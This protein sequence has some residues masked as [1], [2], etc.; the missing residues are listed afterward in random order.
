MRRSGQ[1]GLTLILVPAFLF[2]LSGPSARSQEA[3]AQGRRIGTAMTPGAP[4]ARRDLAVDRTANQAEV[5]APPSPTTAQPSS[6]EI[7]AMMSGPITPI[8]LGTALRLAGVQNP[9]ILVARQ[10]VVEAVALRQ[11]A[12]AQ[13]LPTLNAGSEL[14]HPHRRPPAVQRQHPERQPERPCSS[15]RVRTR[16]RPAR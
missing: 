5:P 14:R 3:I 11:F 2:G 7:S 9:D 10:R 6:A 12:A 16:S 4:D 1:T 13:I 8:D 15:A